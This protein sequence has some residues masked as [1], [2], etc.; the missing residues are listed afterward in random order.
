MS[1]PKKLDDLEARLGYRFAN[2]SLLEQALTHASFLPA[3]DARGGSYQRLEFLGD[4]VLGLTIAA[5][6]FERYPDAPEGQLS[7]ALADLVRKETCAAVAADLGLSAHLRLGK[8]E[9]RSGLGKKIAVLGDSCE[10]LL[11]AIYRD[12][13]FAAADSVV[14]ALWTNRVP[15]MTATSADP[16]THLQEWAHTRSFSEPRYVEQSRVGPDHAPVFR[17]HAI[18]GSL[19]PAE[20]QGPSKR[21][22]ERAAAETMLKREGVLPTNE[23]NAQ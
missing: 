22:A 16:K 6:L 17:V 4:R 20:G 5:M 21:H 2:R 1:E 11:G 9:Q 18:V 14:R 12:A 23:K 19:A 10:A 8:G 13:G 7:R 3:D 15:A